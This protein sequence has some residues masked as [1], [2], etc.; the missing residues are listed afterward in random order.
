M[1]NKIMKK[2]LIS[3]NASKNSNKLD[4]K[5]ILILGGALGVY[6]FYMKTLDKIINYPYVILYVICI[7]VF[8]ILFLYELK[9]LVAVFKPQK[10]LFES[11]LEVLLYIIRISVFSWFISGI[12]LIPFNYYNIYVSESNSR[13]T[14]Y[15]PIKSVYS[16]PRNNVI[17]Y[18]FRGKT[19]I[20]YGKIKIMD[21]IFNNKNYKDYQLIMRVHA[22]LFN[23]YVIEGWD[24]EKNNK[25]H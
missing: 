6:F 5:T 18:E 15:L 22:A 8:T 3:S 11:I 25:M 16:R 9:T 17:Y 4:A 13:E 20:L 2:N 21:E 23:S 19:K 1:K 14:L 10:I 24:I 7:V 12:L